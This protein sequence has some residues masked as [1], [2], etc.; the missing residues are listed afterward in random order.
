MEGIIIKNESNNYTVKCESNY[1]ICKPRGKFR[2]VHI[3]PLVGDYVTIDENNNYILEI[4]KRKNS[5]IRPAVSN[6]DLAIIVTSV[7]SPMLDLNLLDRLLTIISYNNITPVI[8]LS[9]IDLLTSSEKKKITEIKTYYKKI[10]YV[11]VDNTQINTIKKIIKDKIVVITGQSGA[12]KSSLLNK[13]DHTLNLKTD[14]ISKALGRGKHTTRCTSLYEIA[15]SLV[16]DTPGFSSVDFLGMSA[17]D[18]RDNMKEMFDNLPKCQ[19]RD[20]MHIKEEDCEVKR[21]L[22]KG[23]ILTSRYENYKSFI[24]GGK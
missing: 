21:L 4:K 12:G 20:C 2:S 23:Q 7:K 15:S 3:T 10:G 18:I 19:Y 14:E 16:V 8:C 1:Y 22:A 24:R 9:K 11:I 6:V 5:L 13:L 17:T